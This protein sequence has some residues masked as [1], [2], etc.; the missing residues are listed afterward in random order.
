MEQPADT[1]RGRIARVSSVVDEVERRLGRQRELNA[2]K[3]DGY[4]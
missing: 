2:L 1:L 3:A 4:Q